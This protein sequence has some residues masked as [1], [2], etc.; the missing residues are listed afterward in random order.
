MKRKTLQLYL[1]IWQKII[2]LAPKLK[3]N[4]TEVMSDF[5]PAIRKSI[6]TVI[7]GI[8]KILCCWFHYCQV[9]IIFLDV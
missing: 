6:T 1:A 2:P 8:L 4:L 7:P 9:K 5:E 3:L